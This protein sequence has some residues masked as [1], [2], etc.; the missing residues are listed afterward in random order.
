[1]S[2]ALDKPLISVCLL[3]HNSASF[4]TTALES[5]RAQTFPDWELLVSD[6]ASTDHTGDLVK[7]YLEH[8]RIRYIY[9]REN[10]KQANNWAFA[11]A[12]TSAPIIATLHADDAWEPNALQTFANAF[13]DRDDLDLVWANWD[14]YDAE[15]EIRQRSGPVRIPKE[16]NG[17]DAC[18][19]LLDNNDILPS[20]AAFSREAA[21]RAGSPNPQFGML[22]DRHYFLQLPMVARRCRAIPKVVMRYRRNETGVTSLYSRSGRLQEEMIVF[23]NDA[24]ELFRRHPYGSQLARKLQVDF[25][26]DLFL[27]GMAALMAGD[28]PQGMR[29]IKN[30][31]KLAKWALLKP[32]SL[33]G[34]AR[35]LKDKILKAR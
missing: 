10:L 32:R 4:I 14:F 23:A 26:Q 13:Q 6:D 8:P 15:L 16:M 20:A 24:E 17:N 21:Q 3:A 27:H 22:C 2:F 19:W 28:R 11:I 7:P 5:V 18:A 25:G 29:W 35:T 1:L 12:N 34:I 9:H 30:A 33:R 31:M